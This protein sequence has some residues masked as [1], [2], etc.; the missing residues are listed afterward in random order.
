MGGGAAV[1]APAAGHVRGGR[2][3]DRGN[4]GALGL[5]E[6]GRAGLGSVLPSGSPG[7]RADDAPAHRVPAYLFNRRGDGVQRCSQ[8]RWV[9][10]S[11]GKPWSLFPAAASPVSAA[12][13]QQRV[14]GL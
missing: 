1:R 9:V 13:E 4:G 2:G 6:D 7:A 5:S 11:L 3:R 8:P 14:S 10:F 12:E